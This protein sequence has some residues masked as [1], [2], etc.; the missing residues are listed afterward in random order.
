MRG[1]YDPNPAPLIGLIFLVLILGLTNHNGKSSQRSHWL[2]FIVIA[3]LCI[4]MVFFCASSDPPADYHP[5]APVTTLFF[6]SSDYIL[7]RKYQPELQP[8]G[9]KPLS[10][11][12]LKERLWWATSLAGNTRGIG[13]TH[14]PTLHIPPRPSS[15][16]GKFIISQLM[17]LV[18]YF[19][20]FDLSNILIRKNP[21][22]AT[23]GPSLTAFGWLW[24]LTAL[25]HVSSA[26]S[27]LSMF[28][29]A[30]SIISVAIGI[31]EPRDWPH[32]F[33]SPLDGY[34]VQNCWGRVWHQMLRKLVTGHANFISKR[35][36]L[37]KSTFTTCFKLFIAFS[38]SG[39]IHHAAEYILYQKWD[40]HSVEFFLLQAVAI[41]C[42]NMIIKLVARAGF[43]S[44]P[45]RFFKFI[46]FLWVFIWFAYTLPLWLD[47]QSRAGLMDKQFNF[48]FILGLWSGDWTLSQ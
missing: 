2:F 10:E 27:M 34:T 45:N 42:E 8:L 21:C 47:K 29:I 30:Y 17:W 11:M 4:Y 23:G 22:F 13:W 32:L 14:E 37:R 1:K 41:T 40:G 16:R 12:P 15:T 19:F 28:Y 36:R 31:S 3:S 33:G 46:G 5:I 43:S 44:K 39:L 38:V 35:L 6:M 24:R 20:Q 25:L 7:L 9:Q 26:Y 18:I 48:S